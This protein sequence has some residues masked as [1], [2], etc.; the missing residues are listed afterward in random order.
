MR[1]KHS[2]KKRY[3]TS[4]KKY[5]EKQ[6]NLNIIHTNITYKLKKK[7]WKAIWRLFSTEVIKY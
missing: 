2:K 3:D 6:K 1:Q 4:L 7:T 5:Y